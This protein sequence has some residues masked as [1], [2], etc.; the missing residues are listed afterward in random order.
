MTSETHPT[1]HPTSP[2]AIPFFPFYLQT[3]CTLFL[4]NATRENV[5]A[6]AR[7][8]TDNPPL[9]SSQAQSLQHLLRVKVSKLQIATA[10]YPSLSTSAPLPKCREFASILIL[11]SGQLRALSQLLQSYSSPALT[12]NFIASPATFSLTRLSIWPLVN[13]LYV[14]RYWISREAHLRRS[15][16]FIPFTFGDASPWA[17]PFASSVLLLSFS[18]TWI[19]LLFSA[20]DDEFVSTVRIQGQRFEEE[21]NRV[22]LTLTLR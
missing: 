12:A 18:V 7:L 22:T 5:I 13:R 17:S 1:L 19:S 9:N 15:D 21:I 10:L 3:V 4:Y 8:G 20:P 11:F 2:H 14:T 16:N 6:V